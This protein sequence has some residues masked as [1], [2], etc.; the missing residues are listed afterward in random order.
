VKRESVRGTGRDQTGATSVTMQIWYELEQSGQA[1]LTFDEVLDKVSPRVPAGYAWR[2]YIKQRHAYA[3]ANKQRRHGSDNREDAVARLSEQP[4]PELRTT[5]VRYV[6]RSLLAGMVAGGTALKRPDGRFAA[7]RKPRSA[8]TDEQHDFDGSVTH[9]S[10][11][12]MELLRL[13]RPFVERIESEWLPSK[14]PGHMPHI[15]VTLY[16]ALARLVEAHTQ[17]Q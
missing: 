2:R 5:A 17:Q 15:P 13:A 12:L 3:A 11:A 14:A 6:V 16:A 9:K 1:G 7:L 8:Y 10:V 4:T